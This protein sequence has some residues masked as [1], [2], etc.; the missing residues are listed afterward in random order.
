MSALPVSNPIVIEVPEPAL[1]LMVAPSGAGKSTFALQNFDPSEVIATDGCRKILTGT[2]EYDDRTC[3]AAFRLF[4][5]IIKERLA[6]G[7]L[8]V[9]DATNLLAYSR[10]ALYTLAA[11]FNVPV[12]A[13]ALEVPLEECVRRDGA[14]LRKVSRSIIENQYAEFIRTKAELARE[15]LESWHVLYAQEVPRVVIQRVRQ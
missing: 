2:E 10:Q 11:S 13:L 7:F 9:A 1:V 12:V 15:P 3:D 4:H 8:T 14:R 6:A 5:F